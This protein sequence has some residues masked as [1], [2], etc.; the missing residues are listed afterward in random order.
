MGSKSR[1]AVQLI[2]LAAFVL[3][4]VTG[5]IQL[6]M[7]VFLAGLIGAAFFGRFYCGYLCPINTLTE[8]I[9]W[10][11]QKMGIKR[12]DV[13]DWVKSK[14]VRYGV[15]LLF[16]GTMIIT[17]RTGRKLPV[18]PMLTVLGVLITLIYVPSLWHRYLCPY[19]TLLNITG[20]LSKYYWR[21]EEADCKKCGICERVCPT[22]AVIMSGKQGYPVIDKGL[23]LEC[24][25]CAEKCPSNSI[26]Y[27]KGAPKTTRA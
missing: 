1:R 19:G 12:K 20:S 24:T 18:L 21:V 7:A 2:F 10:L 5:K 26:I 22:E 15:L 23:C 6:W 11:Y 8:G 14:V 3:L 16:L 9:D 17:L 4:M 27:A 13:P 25:T